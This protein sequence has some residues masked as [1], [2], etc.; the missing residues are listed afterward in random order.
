MQVARLLEPRTERT[1][2]RQASPDRA[3]H[4]ARAQ[5]EQ[6]RDAR[7][8][9]R[10]SRPMAAISKACARPRSPISAR[11]RSR[12]SLGEAALLV[13]L[14][15]SPE[16][17]RPD[18]SAD[19]ARAR[20]RPRARPHRH[21]RP[22]FR[23]TRSRSPSASR[24]RP[25][26]GR[27]RRSRRMPPIRRSRPR[28]SS[29][30]HRLTI[31]AALQKSLEDLA[32]ERA[33]ALGPDISVAI[34]AVDNATGEVLARVASADYF[35]ER[36]A[37]QVDMTAGAALAR[38]GAE[39]VHLRPRLRGRHRASRNA[40]R[41][42][43]GALRRLRAGEFRSDVPG[44]GDGAPRAAAVAQRAGGGAARRRRRE[45]PAPRASRRPAAPLVLP[46][47]EAPGLAMALGGVG[48]TL[49]DLTMLYAGL[50][51]GGNAVPLI[52]RVDATRAPRAAPP[53]RSGRRL[54]CRQR[55]DRHAAA[56]E[57]RRRPHRLQD[58]HLLRLSR[59]LVGRLRRQA[60]HRRLGRPAGRRAGAG[61]GRAHRRGADPVRR[62]RAHRR[63]RRRRCR[64]RR[65][66]R[67]SRP[68]RKLPPPLQH[69]RPNG[70]S[71]AT[72]ARR[73]CASCSRR[74]TRASS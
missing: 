37:G 67:C 13:A 20:A 49:T 39:A 59:R 5:P 11:S 22:T 69:F 21:G 62:L 41:G 19:A 51:R 29:K 53:A 57:R 50:A 61:P 45:P 64:T 6:G 8:L 7:A 34:L 24:C 58:R 35:D 18:R 46:K 72:A 70:A 33:R 48:I 66:A 17:R 25:A 2:R 4:R 12:L 9:S 23:P 40:D 44:H 52:E 65:R 60:H 47:G 73:R 55:A 30:V 43:P 56:G 3:R 38:L 54:V 15:Q 27:C 74:T 31:D 68:A 36:R 42:S 32:R 16:L 26:A 14:P 28:R 1:L 10:R 71:R 63:R